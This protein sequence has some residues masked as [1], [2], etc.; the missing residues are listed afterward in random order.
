M[1]IRE[2]GMPEENKWNAFFN[3]KQILFNL[4]INSKVQQ[5]VEIGSGYGTFSIPISKIIS[6]KVHAFD[7]ETDMIKSLEE[8]LKQENITNIITQNR[9]ILSEG[10][11][12]ANSSIDYIVLFNIMHHKKPSELYAEAFRILKNG[13]KIGII[14]WRSDI[15]TPRGPSLSIRPK[16]EEL[17]SQIDKEKFNVI[18]EPFI[19]EP[20]HYGILLEKN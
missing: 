5:L 19:L 7:M 6:G 1:K 14:H 10:S 2:S 20:Y 8:K 15:K 9:D 16:P 11:G 17:L 12:L 18:K 13:G 3:I 4:E